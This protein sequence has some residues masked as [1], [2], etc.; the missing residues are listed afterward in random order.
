MNNQFLFSMLVLDLFYIDICSVVK[1]GS[2]GNRAA[3]R[4]LR[5]RSKSA[6]RIE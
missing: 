5:E 4:L 2:A 3:L 6:T 1:L